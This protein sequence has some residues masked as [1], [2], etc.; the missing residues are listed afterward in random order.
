M[1]E[2]LKKINNECLNIIECK[3]LNYEI[4]LKK[5]KT[6]NNDLITNQESYINILC[7]IPFNNKEYKINDFY[8]IMVY[9]IRFLDNKLMKN[10]ATKIMNLILDNENLYDITPYESPLLSISKSKNIT[11]E[12][13]L[14]VLNKFENDSYFVFCEN[15]IGEFPYDNRYELIKN[16]NLDDNIKEIIF[17]KYNDFQLNEAINEMYFDITSKMNNN[18][19]ELFEFKAYEVL[20]KELENIELKEKVIMY[21][22]YA[23]KQELREA[24]ILNKK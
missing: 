21:A 10:K 3:D 4:D 6:I 9:Y 23:N 7:G 15:Y 18:E 14:K 8:N 22:K 11:N 19:K 5:I 13:A 12:I 2:K 20:I 24:K 16:N 1:I 17:S